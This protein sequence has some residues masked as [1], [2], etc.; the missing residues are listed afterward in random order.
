MPIS[1]ILIAT[2]Q[3]SAIVLFFIV[4][5]SRKKAVKQQIGSLAVGLIGSG[6]VACGGSILTPLLGA[7][8]SNVSVALAE[9]ISD[10]L[11]LI[12]V[13]LSYRALSQISLVYAREVAKI[14]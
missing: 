9:R 14:P 5:R 6:C 8:A 12:A 4:R 10:I 3:A 13:L 2:F 7:V 11:L 1:I